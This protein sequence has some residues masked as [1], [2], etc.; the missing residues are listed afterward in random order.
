MTEEYFFCCDFS[1]FYFSCVNSIL[2]AYRIGHFHIVSVHIFEPFGCVFSHFGPCF[3]RQHV[4]ELFSKQRKCGCRM[5]HDGIDKFVRS[6]RNG[7]Q[8]FFSGNF[9]TEYFFVPY[10]FIRSIRVGNAIF[11]IPFSFF[12][13]TVWIIK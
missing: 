6:R 3:S 10:G 1:V 7:Y 9:K 2:I 12:Q 4:F 5:F 13:L 8:K 11:P